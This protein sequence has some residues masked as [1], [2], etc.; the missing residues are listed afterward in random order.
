[1]TTTSKRVSALTALL[2]VFSVTQVYVGVT[3]AG[4]TPERVA[5]NAT[6]AG[7]GGVPQQTGI[8][9]TNGNKPIN[10][11]GASAITGA[12]VLSGTSIET[13]DGVGATINLS[14]LGWIDISPNT[15]FSLT[16]E[17]GSIKIMLIEGCVVLHS[18]KGTT[19]EIDTAQGVVGKTDPARDGTLRVCFP[20]GAAAPIAN[21]GGASGAGG[22]GGAG[23]AAGAGGAGGG[24]LF[25]LTT[26][27]GVAI[28]GGSVAAAAI[29]S[30]RGGN[31]S[32][33]R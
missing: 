18:K 24:G 21:A 16:F 22:A 4:P 3:F 9:K 28:I 1:M 23:G 15:K 14:S 31:P 32:P 7:A 17:Q 10:I 2:L 8:L 29:T 12:T 11:N 30:D 19:G 27:A 26:L 5:T 25:T 33:F 6:A 13:P 20:K